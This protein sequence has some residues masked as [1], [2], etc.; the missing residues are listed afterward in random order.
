[1]DPPDV[2]EAL[3]RRLNAAFT[4]LS[5]QDGVL[6]DRLN[7]RHVKGYLGKDI[8]FPTAIL[9]DKDGIVRWIYEMAYGNVRLTPAELFEAI[10]RVTLEEQNRELRRG[11]AVSHVVKQVFLMEKS[12]DLGD[13]IGLMRDE[14]LGLGLR[15]SFCGI[16]IFDEERAVSKTYSANALESR[17]AT[18][19]DRDSALP[20]LELPLTGLDDLEQIVSS[21]RKG[22]IYYRNYDDEESLTFLSKLT[23]HGPGLRTVSPV[24]SIL[25]VPFVHGTLALAGAAPN[26]YTE[27]EVLTLEEFAEA[28]SVGYKRFLDFHEL[29]QRNLELQKTQLQ[30]V[31]SEK[32][33]S[34]GELVA[35]VAHEL[36]TP[37]GAI[38]SNTQIAASAL[39]KVRGSLVSGDSS[40]DER[41]GLVDILEQLETLNQVNR[42]A[43]ERI[44]QIVDSLR[45]FARL[46]EAEWKPAELHQGLD[47]TLSLIRHKLGEKI[48]VSKNYG[49]L[50]QITCYPKQ[51]N[52]VFMMLLMNAIQAMNGEGAIRICT[53]RDA[54]N[55]IIEI[56][57]TGAGIDPEILPRIFDPGFT[58]KG[59]G[60]GI[61]LGLSICYKI[62]AEHNGRIDVASEAGKG[63]NIYSDHPDPSVSSSGAMTRSRCHRK[64]IQPF[65][66]GRGC[67][68]YLQVLHTDSRLE[69]RSVNND[70]PDVA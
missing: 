28:I 58:T 44:I 45:S 9:A 49:E 22:E 46:D 27:D 50:P 11:R 13:V 17:Q 66:N 53:K 63:R 26:Q 20:Y 24:R 4:F 48:S 8:A 64:P 55:A 18:A 3:R 12:A 37:L 65:L 54:S 2:S 42:G 52:Q 25:L 69:T 60:V 32:M 68:G 10:Q 59:V 36:N 5:D 38:K 51:M 33:A 19:D 56:S 21:W 62:I 7:I 30:L 1:M 23:S 29:D 41:G 34:L 43:S 16:T 67:S 35:G 40:S 31:Q 57:D 39:E 70:K 14:L 6:L 15:F 47:D 61:G